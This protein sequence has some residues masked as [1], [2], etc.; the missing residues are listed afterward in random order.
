MLPSLF[1]W[2][3][4]FGG[5]EL[6]FPP[7]PKPLALSFFRGG[8]DPPAHTRVTRF[9]LTPAPCA[10]S[11]RR[12]RAIRRHA[13]REAAAGPAIRE[14]AAGPSDGAT[15]LG[16]AVRPPLSAHPARRARGRRRRGRL[17]NHGRSR[18]FRFG[19]VGWLSGRGRGALP[20]IF[21]RRAVMPRC[22]F[23]TGVDDRSTPPPRFERPDFSF[24]R[25]ALFTRVRAADH[26]SRTRHLARPVCFR[27]RPLS[28]PL[29]LAPPRL[30]RRSPR[31]HSRRW[32]RAAGRTRSRSAR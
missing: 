31:P 6:S 10:T 22:P 23:L 1:L 19:G 24:R 14:A 20:L 29:A 13:A 26:R 12:A 25:S 11:R 32:A 16:I 21:A 15:P 17:C 8:W 4:S 18:T 3:G 7:S 30:A 28:R 2:G 9:C 27:S 5:F